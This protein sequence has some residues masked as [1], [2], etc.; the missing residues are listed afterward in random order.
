MKRLIKI[1]SRES[2]LAIAQ[3]EIMIES[4]KRTH[5]EFEFE[6]V[7][8]KTKGDILLDT[9]LDIVGGKGM[10]VSELQKALLNE[11]IDIAVHSMK[12]MPSESAEGL[13]IAAVSQR[14]DP[15]DILV[16]EGGIPLLELK[17]GAVIGTSSL[18]REVQILAIRPD[19]RVKSVRG[20]V[21]TRLNK[22]YNKEYDA[23][24]LAAAGLIR[25]GLKEACS[26]YFKISEMIPAIGQG[27]LCVEAKLGSNVDYLK[28]SVHDKDSEYVLK[29]ERSFMMAL[30]GECSTPVAAYAQI[31]ENRVKLYGMY[32]TNSSI[33]KKNLEGN[34][35]DAHAIG[36]ELAK[37]I[38]SS[39]RAR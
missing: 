24:I 15:R 36:E 9:R 21:L 31:D 10:F 1:G 25:L 32:Y 4:I 38:L 7:K 3:T 33:I 26:E 11:E 18:R 30:N 19:L 39:A 20:N 6:I 35:E 5:P 23:L 37:M 34:K 16:T 22:L 2:K 17:E 27:I 28:D 13:F 12:D 29:A 8:M 14:E